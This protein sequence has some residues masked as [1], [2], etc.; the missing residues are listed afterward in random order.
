[1][2][3][4]AGV[5]ELA[6]LALEAADLPQYLVDFLALMLELR[7]AGGK[8]GDELREL[9]PV[10]RR[11]IVELQHLAYLGEGEAEPLAAQDQL[12]AH[13]VALGIDAPRSVAPGAEQAFVLVEADCAMGHVELAREVGDAVG[14]GGLVHRR[15]AQALSG[16][17]V[18]GGAIICENSHLS[19]REA[20]DSTPTYSRHPKRVTPESILQYPHAAPPAPGEALQVAPGVHWLRMPLPFALDHINLWLLEDESNG[21]AGGT[22]VDC[23]IGDDATRA[24]WERI[25]A[26]R[27]AGRPVRRLIV[28]HHHPDHAGLASW[29]AERTGAEFWMPQAEYFAAH[30]MR[31]GSA[32]FGF[33]NVVAMFVRNGLAGEK[34][35][36]MKQ[37]RTSYRSRV[38]GFPF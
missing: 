29:L 26:A 3:A 22:F 17:F 24:L 12:Q 21:N 35:T 15:N 4:S 10:V 5:Q 33:D 1:M 18:A 30:A 6:R 27:I 23:G 11:R 20:P 14:L 32:G 34:L 25:F 16:G 9:R 7:A 36:L 19:P 28:T 37:R 2:L 31:E 8:R 38:P 13:P